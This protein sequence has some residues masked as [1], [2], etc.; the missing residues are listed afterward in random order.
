MFGNVEFTVSNKIIPAFE[1]RI[2]N[3]VLL[4]ASTLKIT[5]F[6]FKTRCPSCGIPCDKIYFI[7]EVEMKKVD[8][9]FC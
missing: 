5:E 4:K 3:I 6:F 9:V 8:L 1:F 2:W 7:Y